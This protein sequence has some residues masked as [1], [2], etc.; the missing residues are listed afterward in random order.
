MA[1]KTRSLKV[2]PPVVLEFLLRSHYLADDFPSIITTEGFSQFCLKNFV[3]LETTQALLNRTTLCGTFSAPRT[4]TTRRVLALPNPISQLALSQILTAERTEIRKS[5]S[6]S[7]ITLYNTKID[8]K[9]K[10]AFF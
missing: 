9:N 8:H 10:R 1:S 6:S 2:P 4:P 3:T 7:G 5:I